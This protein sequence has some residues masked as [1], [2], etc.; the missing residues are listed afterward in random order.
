MI[1]IGAGHIG[2]DGIVAARDAGVGRPWVVVDPDPAARA[3]AEA[4]LG[5]PAV[6]SLDEVDGAYELAFVAFSSKAAVA[7]PL[8]ARLLASGAHVI[9]TCEELA[10]PTAKEA[11]DL[12]SACREAGRSVVV[13]GANPGF[14]M[15]RVPMLLTGGC[16]DVRSV[17]V[18]RRVDTRTRRRSL[19]AKT[20]YGMTPGEFS[21]AAESGAIGHVGL[22]ASAK[23]LAAGLGWRVVGVT[24]SLEPIVGGE[25]V[26]GQDQRLR[27]VCE[28]GRSIDLAL[29]MAWGLDEPGD[30]ISIRGATSLDVQIQGGFPGDEGTTARMVNAAR[31]VAALEPG[32]YG[33]IDLPVTV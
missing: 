20:G 29:S 27:L 14:V 25:S 6:E 15:D 9:T 12:R 1:L 22:E 17:S 31:Q 8:V 26:L 19:V 13:T 3:A 28:G 32:F 4:A 33:P 16:R 7:A 18:V 10:D 24:L 11:N 2:V 21:R 23:A 5:V 30:R